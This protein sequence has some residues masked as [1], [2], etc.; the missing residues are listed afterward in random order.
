MKQI[1][2]RGISLSRLCMGAANFGYQVEERTAFRLMDVFREQGGNLIDTANVYCRWIDGENGSEKL[3]GRYLASRGRHSIHIA[4]K[5]CHYDFSDP[6]TSRVTEAEL[7]KD[8]ESS[9]SAL[10]LDCIEFYWLHRDNPALPIEEILSFCEKLVKEGKIRE[11]GASNFT[12]AR[13]R[14]ARLKSMEYG[15]SGFFGLSNSFSAAKERA[16]PDADPTLVRADGEQLAFL[17]ETDMPLFA[18]SAGAR[19]YFARRSREGDSF[20]PSHDPAF[21]DAENDRR[22]TVLAAAARESG[23]GI[24]ACA[25]AALLALP[26]TVI[27]I[28][29]VSSE[30]H[31][32]EILDGEH[33]TLGEEV[34]RSLSLDGNR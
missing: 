24:S 14:E 30:A 22:F 26:A 19:G 1:K 2:V 17:R 27:P 31:L 25:M 9:L 11:Y 12:T 15:F 20:D 8:V 16:V 18:Y 3:L 34:M 13:M 32:S 29:S 21:A 10:G 7:R 23:V 33:M 28:F 4:T 6:K 5:G